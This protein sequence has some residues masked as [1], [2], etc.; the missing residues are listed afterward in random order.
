MP[1]LRPLMQGDRLPPSAGVCVGQLRAVVWRCVQRQVL[2]S[3]LRTTKRRYLGGGRA[4][5]NSCP[6]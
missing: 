1:D 3:Q 2:S 5:S 6:H 4:A